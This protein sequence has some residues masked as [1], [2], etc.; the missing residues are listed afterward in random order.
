MQVQARSSSAGVRIFSLQGTRVRVP[1]SA[2]HRACEALWFGGPRPGG[3]PLGFAL[4]R[5][6]CVSPKT[7]TLIGITVAT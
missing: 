7:I 6:S 3:A 4:L 5:A 1:Y 2:L